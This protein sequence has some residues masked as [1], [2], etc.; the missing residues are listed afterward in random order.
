MHRT[1][2]DAAQKG[3]SFSQRFKGQMARP[4]V[5]PHPEHEEGKRVK[6]RNEWR[7]ELM[8]EQRKGN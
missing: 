6:A 8:E 2:G 1:G 4:L 7:G 3:E 5:V